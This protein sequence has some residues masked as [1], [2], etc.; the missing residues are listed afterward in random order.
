VEWHLNASSLTLTNQKFEGFQTITTGEDKKV[1][2]M[3]IHADDV[4]L[5][6]MVTYNDT[7][8]PRVYSDGGKGKNV[9]LTNVT[10]HVLQQKGTLVAP[11]P[12]GPVTL[13][14]PGEAGSDLASQAVMALLQL[15]LPLP[16][17]VFTN[18]SVDQYMLQS[19]TLDIPGFN[20][21]LDNSQPRG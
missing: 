9:H 14:P 2:V 15:N 20:I 7:G 16:P 10:L 6:N 18:V 1:T 5:I 12:V 19:D 4:D 13:G 17:S 8:T 3:A 11:L 21:G